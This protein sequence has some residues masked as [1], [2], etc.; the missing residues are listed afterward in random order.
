VTATAQLKI[1][2]WKA[3]APGGKLRLFRSPEPNGEAAPAIFGVFPFAHHPHLPVI[4]QNPAMQ[5]S[6]ATHSLTNEERQDDF[7]P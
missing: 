7:L 3:L 4:L 1:P 6:A 2:T 5:A